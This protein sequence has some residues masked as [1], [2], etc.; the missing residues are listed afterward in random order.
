MRMSLARHSWPIAADEAP[1][2]LGI[3]R[4]RSS[5]Q[6]KQH[7]KRHR[8][9]GFRRT[10]GVDVP[11][12]IAEAIP[13]SLSLIGVERLQIFVGVAWNNVEV[14][15]LRRFRFAIHEQRQTLGTG[16]AEPLFDGQ[17]VALRLGNFLAV[18]VEK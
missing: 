1:E 12:W 5:D 9:V 2:R 7:P 4:I 16:V 3:L 15:P 17:S 11:D 6:G 13:R 14:E 18:L 8:V 10:A